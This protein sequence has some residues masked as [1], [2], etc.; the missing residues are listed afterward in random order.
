MDGGKKSQSGSSFTSDLFGSKDSTSGSVFGSLLAPPHKL[1]GRESLHSY[2]C[3]K[4]DDAANQG[5]SGKTGVPN[6][7][8]PSNEEKSQSSRSKDINSY[9]QKEKSNPCN[10]SSSIYYGGQDLYTLPESTQGSFFTTFTDEA[11][12]DS[13]MASRGNWWQ[14]S[15]YY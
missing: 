2:E 15:L 12:D 5:W 1:F 11:G 8:A 13:G 10:Y 7:D 4:K 3:W 6:N 9:F 14:G